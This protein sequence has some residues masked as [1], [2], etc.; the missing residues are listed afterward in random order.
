MSQ[1]SSLGLY[2]LLGNIHGWMLWSS[3][4]HQADSC[5]WNL[6]VLVCR[7]KCKFKI[8]TKLFHKIVSWRRFLCTS[9]FGSIH[10]KNKEIKCKMIWEVHKRHLLLMSAPVVP[11]WDRWK[12]LGESNRKFLRQKRFPQVVKSSPFH[13]K[14][15]FHLP[16]SGFERLHCG[17]QWEFSPWWVSGTGFF[18]SIMFMYTYKRLSTKTYRLVRC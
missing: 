11:G 7:E 8:K 3:V 6:I 2:C 13:G 1:P 17:F 10:L 18:Q 5:W 15:C 12:H 16:E 14:R 9:K 4:G